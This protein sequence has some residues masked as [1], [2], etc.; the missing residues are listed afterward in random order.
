MKFSTTKEVIICSAV[1]YKELPIVE[2]N[3]QALPKNINS[4]VVFCGRNHLQCIRTMSMIFGLRSVEPECGQYVQGFLTN[5][6]RFVDREE[7]ARIAIEA[8]QIESQV[9][10]LY[11]E[12]L[13]DIV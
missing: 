1:W 5:F 3:E 7:G 6:D 4:G 8:K 10:T 13:F 11:S 12:Y 2:F 9:D